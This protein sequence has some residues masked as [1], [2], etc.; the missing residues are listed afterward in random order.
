L[1][2]PTAFRS[3]PDLLGGTDSCAEQGNETY[4]FFPFNPFFP[5]RSRTLL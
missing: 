5:L 4:G 2:K 3:V 1:K